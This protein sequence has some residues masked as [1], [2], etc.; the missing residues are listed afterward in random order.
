MIGK[1]NWREYWMNAITSP[2]RHLAGRDAQAADD[3]DRD[4]VE[5]RDEVHR[6]LDDPGDELRPVARLVE[7]LVLVVE[8]GR[9]P[10]CWRPNTFTIAC[11]V[12]ISSTWP[13]SVPVDAHWATNCFCERLAMRIVTTIEAGTARIE[14]T[15]RIGLIVSIRMS[16]PTIVS[17]E[18]M[19]WVRLCCSD[20]ADVVDVVG[21]AAQ[22][23]A[24]R[25]AVEVL[26]RQPAELA[27]RRPARRR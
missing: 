15:A 3:R 10:R 2:R 7:L 19:S 23:V 13:L 16:T 9:S 14:M 8:L 21:D 26:E 17:S 12:C 6:G 27:C 1:V 22:Q 25:V 24:A 18:V 4:V 11:P 20:L 5:V